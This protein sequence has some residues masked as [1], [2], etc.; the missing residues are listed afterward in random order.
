[1]TTHRSIVKQLEAHPRLLTRVSL[2]AWVAAAIIWSG[3]IS[4]R[5]YAASSKPNSTNALHAAAQKIAEGHVIA[6][7][8]RWENGRI[9]TRSVVA[10]RECFKGKCGAEI[11]LKQ[12]GGSVGGLTMVAHG[13]TLLKQGEAALLFVTADG[14]SSHQS[15]ALGNGV[16]RTNAR[17]DLEGLRTTLRKMKS[18]R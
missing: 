11:E 18:S 5:A 10:V 17:R 8:V 16:V 9:V 1:M 15:V 3:L 7:S 2:V 12:F 6:Q 4:S 14:P 13:V